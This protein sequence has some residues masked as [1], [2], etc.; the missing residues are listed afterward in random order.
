MA[1]FG[2]EALQEVECNYSHDGCVVYGANLMKR[3]L[4]ESFI[5]SG[6]D[7][8][9]AS[10][11]SMTF[12]ETGK[13]DHLP[14]SLFQSF[15][16]LSTLSIEWSEIPIVRKNLFR[17]QFRQIQEL[18]FSHN[19]IK[20]IEKEAFVQLTDLVLIN[21]RGNNIRSLS[22]K[23]IASNLKLERID[24][25]DNKISM[26]DPEIFKNLKHLKLVAL[27]GNECAG[28]LIGCWYCNTNINRTDLDLE[29]QHCYGHYKESMN[30][31][32][33][34]KNNFFVCQVG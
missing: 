29:L 34:G 28:Q 3:T 19:G 12:S 22:E 24:L 1:R 6:S 25:R 4:H 8:E 33:E 21:L 16:K 2:T 5:F 32:M 9:K 7:D 30:L 27:R 18:L 13:V 14:W 17:V 10:A 26:L 31:T 15:P 20:I 23:M 11:T